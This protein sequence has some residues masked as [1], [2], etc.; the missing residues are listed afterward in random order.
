M[1]NKTLMI[2][3]IS[4]KTGFINMEIEGRGVANTFSINRMETELSYASAE[5]KTK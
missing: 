5:V 1:N 3:W 2:P 4:N